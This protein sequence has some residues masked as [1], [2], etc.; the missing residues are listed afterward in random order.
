MSNREIIE[1]LLKSFNLTPVG[2]THY[3]T[4]SNGGQNQVAIGWKGEGVNNL[5]EVV[6]RFYEPD[7]IKMVIYEILRQCEGIYPVYVR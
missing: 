7:G 3:R 6:V 4:S 1:H 2:V 5:G